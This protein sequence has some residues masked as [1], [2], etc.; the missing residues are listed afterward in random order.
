[1]K[2]LIL[3]AMAIAASAVQAETWN[4]ADAISLTNAIAKSAAND[5]IRLAEGTYNLDSVKSDG[6]N[7]LTLPNKALVFEGA[8]ATSWRDNNGRTKAILKGAGALR[9]IMA[10]SHIT[11][12]HITVQGGR[13]D[14][15]AGL[16]DDN[17]YANVVLTNCVFLD[18][19]S[20]ST[21]GAL[22]RMK[23]NDNPVC[24]CLFENN[25][26][27]NAQY[28]QGVANYGVYNNCVFLKNTSAG[29]AAVSTTSTYNDCDFVSNSCTYAVAGTGSTANRCR[30]IDNTATYGTA[31]SGSSATDCAFVGNKAQWGGALANCNATRCVFTNNTATINHDNGGG[32]MFCNDSAAHIVRD[33]TFVGNFSAYHGGAIFGPHGVTNCTFIGNGTVGN[34]GAIINCNSNLAG[35]NQRCA[36]VHCTF[37]GNSATNATAGTSKGGAV[38]NSNLYDC[39][40]VSNRS[41][42]IGG[43]LANCATI[44][45]CRVL[46]NSSPGT[47]AGICCDYGSMTVSDSLIA[48]NRTPLYGGGICNAV[49]VIDC[50]ISNNVAGTLGA[51][52]YSNYGGR[53]VIGCTFVGNQVTNV[54][55]MGGGLAYYSTALGNLVSNCT[56]TAN[57]SSGS[58]AGLHNATNVVMSLFANNTNAFFSGHAWKG[59][60]SQCK[61]TGVGQVA[62]SICDRCEF[63]GFTCHGSEL[64]FPFLASRNSADTYVSEARNCLFHG[65]SE[66]DALVCNMGSTMTV[67]NCTFGGNSNLVSVASIQKFNNGVSDFFPATVFENNLCARNMKRDGSDAGLTIN[68]VAL[69]ESSMDSLTLRNNLAQSYNVS[70]ALKVAVESG[71]VTGNPRVFLPGNKYD[72]PAWMPRKSS[73]AVNAGITYDWSLTAADFAGTDRTF[74]GGVDIGCYEATVDPQ[75]GMFLFFK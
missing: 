13:A 46:D 58:S 16:R 33:C 25:S 38:Y 24:D 41:S 9:V 56:F 63:A 39:T 6:T 68:A 54:N 10:Q 8:D 14:G 73:P 70:A 23:N 69:D 5:T 36:I 59:K 29:V 28:G 50:V 30:F 4:V 61:F 74:N 44:D 11:L 18:N 47:G 12:R 51:G 34:G 35:Y 60:F 3:L 32:A 62:Q 26:C 48:G 15:G 45:K 19:H 21:L 43:G 53:R 71:N 1:M 2:K 57:V 65:N 31:L 22:R 67:Q 55:A 52:L 42:Y 64:N 17:Q 49:D 27:D 20:T 40:V 7:Y 72:A 37:I 66:A 75:S